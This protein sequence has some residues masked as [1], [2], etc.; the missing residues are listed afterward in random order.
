[1]AFTRRNSVR[2]DSKESENGYDGTEMAEAE[3]NLPSTD[4][5]TNQFAI[6]NLGK[7]EIAEI[8]TENLGGAGLNVTDLTIVKV[9]SGGG[10]MWEIPGIEGLQHAKEIEGVIIFTQSTRAYWPDSFDDTGGGSPPQ[11]MSTDAVTGI[12]DPGATEV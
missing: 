11:C 1:M 6:M 4:V 10:V 12:G 2:K 3:N 8:L 5:D 7:N 9:P